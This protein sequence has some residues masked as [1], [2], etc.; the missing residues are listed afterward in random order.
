VGIE[1]TRDHLARGVA[2]GGDGEPS[3][4]VAWPGTSRETSIDRSQSAFGPLAAG[5]VVSRLSGGGGGWGPPFGRDPEAVARDVRDDL[6]SIEEAATVHGVVVEATD[7]VVI[8][9]HA[10]TAASRSMDMPT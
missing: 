2:G 7:G 10:E 1:N 8:I 9:D 3:R 6:L 5:D 4:L